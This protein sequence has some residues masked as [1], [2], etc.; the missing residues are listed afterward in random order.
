MKHKNF[1][2][3][4]LLR[5]LSPNFYSILFSFEIALYSEGDIP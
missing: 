1:M 5:K 4:L 2:A 3:A